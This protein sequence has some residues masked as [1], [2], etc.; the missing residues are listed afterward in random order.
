MELIT[1][2]VDGMP[3]TK[4]SWKPKGR[5][6]TGR[7]ALVPDNPREAAWAQLVAWSFRQALRR[8]PAP[9]K[10]RYRVELHFELEPSPGGRQWRAN[11]RDLDK[12]MRSILDALTGLVWLDDE[13]VDEATL[14][15]QIG[16][17]PGATVRIV[18]L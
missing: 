15:K 2:H 7:I 5:L 3:E 17:R 4:G 13:Q 1:F 12:L 8:P 9:D 16:E 14:G 6:R 18:V 11:R 10:R